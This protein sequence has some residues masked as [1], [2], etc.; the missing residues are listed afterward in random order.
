MNDTICKL[1]ASDFDE[2]IAHLSL[3]FGDPDFAALVPSLYQPTD[4]HMGRNF[5]LRKGGRIAAM[6]GVFPIDWIVG[7]T[8]LRVAGIGGVSVHPDH[9]GMGFMRL[10]MDEA[11][12]E[13]ESGGFHA[14]YLGGNRRRYNHWGFEKAGAEA[15]FTVSTNSLEHDAHKPVHS[16]N[17]AL[18]VS[19]A[20]EDE[21]PALHALMQRQ[22]IRCIRTAD[23]FP[24]HLRN[25]RR[26]PLVVRDLRGHA[27]GY[28]CFDAN[29]ATCVECCVENSEALSALLSYCIGAAKRPV[30]V[31]VPMIRD[32]QF[33]HLERLA[34]DASLI[35]AGNWRIYQWP[36]VMTALLKAR[37]SAMPL[38]PDTFVIRIDANASG[39]SGTG[40][41]HFRLTIDSH[42]TCEFSDDAPD[43]EGSAA[44]VLRALTDP[45]PPNLPLRAAQLGLWRPLPL[46]IPM[47]DRV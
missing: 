9:R 25:W 20:T 23:S 37:Q 3:V 31:S 19:E 42:A 44:Q 46:V 13:I 28:T 16:G 2:A 14:A 4:S 41:E 38:P 12:A 7:S 26:R 29:D 5:A 36:A 35:E 18:T 45:I 6:V 21:L 11:M 47:Q 15:Q 10:L 1:T 32:L 39:P 43:F 27:L 17:G 33:N 22:P 8:R 24:R 40:A 34:D 30:R